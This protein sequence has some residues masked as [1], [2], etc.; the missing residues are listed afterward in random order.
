MS[1]T[2]TAQRR[3]PAAKAPDRTRRIVRALYGLL[4]ACLLAYLVSV[5]IRPASDSWP[6]LDNWGVGAF[7]IV[8]SALCLGRSLTVRRGRAIPLALGGAL[9]AWAVGD[10]ALSAESLGGATPPTPSPA[11]AFYLCFYPLAYVGIMLLVRRQARR[12]SAATWLDGA[13]AG[14][15]AATICAVFAFR[16]L[17]SSVGG[18]AAE[19]ATNLAYPV[20]DLLLLMLVVGGTAVLPDR[21][22]AR[23]L[24]LAAG[25]AI[26]A[27]GDTANLLHTSFGS[28]HLGVI[29]NSVAWPTSILL[30]S[31]S[32]WMRS[33]P[34]EQIGHE[35]PPGLVLPG[36]AAIA[37]LVIL[38]VSSFTSTGHI[39]AGLAAATLVLAGIRAA[40]S[41]I[42]LS[43]LTEERHGQA[44]TDELTDLGNRRAL[45]ELLDGLL[46]AHEDE[47]GHGRRLAFLFVDLN[48]F[49]EIN[50]S[51]GHGAGDEVLRQLGARLKGTLR[52]SDLLVRLGGDEFAVLLLDADAD[53]GATIAQRISARLEEPFLIGNVAA[54][55]SASIGIALVPT[56]ATRAQDLL[57]R[58]DLAMYRA[59]V[60]G[61]PFAIYQEEIDGHG[62][63]L[64]LVE[65][66][67]VAIEERRLE[68]H[69]Q[70]QVDLRTGEVV[71]VEALARWCHE[72]HGFI[73]P[74]EFLPLAEDAGLMDQLTG[75]VLDE[76]LG[77][78]AV[79]LAE[80]RPVT[81]A[82]NISATNLLNP[83]FPAS[84]GHL[85]ERHG[86]HPSMLVLEITETTTMADV[87]RCRQAIQ[88]LAD[89]GLVVSVD[90]FG[91]GFTS[92]AYLS[93]LAVGELKLD[94]SFISGL[95]GTSDSRDLALV[96]STVKLA[97]ALGLR[98]VA[99]GIEDDASFE[100]L[101]DLACDLA[102]GYLIS[103]PRP[104]AELVFDA[105]VAPVPR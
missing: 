18:G 100:M 92:L 7:E 36:A 42:R 94:R 29:I 16:T 75:L 87:D 48:R 6:W 97:H 60:A 95:S 77:Q 46:E 82:V 52:A 33:G 89:L 90:D 61:K 68:L 34:R 50:D 13:V 96:G 93:S 55:I 53:Y 2:H 57:R 11:D 83:A 9:L 17:M 38:V 85:L 101:T 67:R 78:C 54:R 58:A 27:T 80:K 66:L 102:Q 39:A 76:A 22:R 81:V 99:E 59:K 24:L 15:G 84:V 45:F 104:A 32:M 105:Y 3:R 19:V 30:I 47:D 4:A 44:I 31:A 41:L 43:T 64:A 51:F 49:K 56:D 72:P 37:A 26:N 1:E 79:W 12:F 71:A 91:A 103:R 74:L 5:I 73:P 20:G 65:D 23:W 35:R 40:L 69:Y 8:A 70:P 28:T 62:N 98:V 10:L 88:E 63:R 86:L 21:R 14:L 25:C